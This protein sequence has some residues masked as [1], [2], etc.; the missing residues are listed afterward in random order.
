MANTAQN[1]SN[2]TIHYVGTLTDGTQFDSS[3]E[4]GEPM[5]ITLGDGQ[6]IT[7]F[8]DAL[9]GMT[10]GETKEFTIASDD[11]YGPH[12]EDR[13][14][15]IDRSIFPENFEFTTGMTVPLQN[16]TGQNFLAVITEIADDT[17]T[18]DF[19]HPLAGKDLTFTVDVLAVSENEDT[20]S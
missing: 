1:G 5:T 16:D 2:V 3:R 13:L 17:V 8:N 14:T 20:D 7:G 19:N 11:A 4:R 18:A 15:P 12:H 10:E 9:I 6:L